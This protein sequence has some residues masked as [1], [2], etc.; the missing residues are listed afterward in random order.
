[1]ARYSTV[2]Q[3]LSAVTVAGVLSTHEGIPMMTNDSSR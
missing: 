3:P 2:A 1:M